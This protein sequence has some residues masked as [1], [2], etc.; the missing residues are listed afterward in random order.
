MSEN[1]SGGL[2]HFFEGPA[3]EVEVPSDPNDVMANHTNPLIC[4]E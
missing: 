4:T 1:L 3:P 2:A